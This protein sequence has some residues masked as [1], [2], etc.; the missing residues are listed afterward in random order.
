M[1]FGKLLAQTHSIEFQKSGYLH[2]H[3]SVWLDRDN[4]KH[5]DAELISM[6]ICAKTPTEV[7][8]QQFDA[9]T[10]RLLWLENPTFVA[11]T[12]FMVA[13]PCNPTMA[14]MKQGYCKYVF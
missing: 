5:M 11:V 12:S 9:I 1:I 7:K 13:G 4:L 3:I 10:K 2:T 8:K 6:L 14:Y